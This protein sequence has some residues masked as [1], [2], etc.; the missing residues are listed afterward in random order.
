MSGGGPAVMTDADMIAQFRALSVWRRGDR[1]A[2]HKPLLVLIALARLQRG[3]PRLVPYT[4]IQ[5]LLADLI[6]Q[7]GPTRNVQPDLP[8]WY[9]QNDGV[10]ELPERE[11]LREAT[12]HLKQ[13]KHIPAKYLVE[14]RAEAGIPGRLYALLRDRPALVN[15]I[16]QTLLD[17]TFPP[18][19]HEEILDAVGMPWVVANAPRA[20][21]DPEFRR[22]IIRAYEHRCAICGYDGRLG[23]AVLGLEAAHVRWH[24][25]G[26]PDTA[27]NGLALCTFHHKAFDRG[28]L[29][30][31]DDLEVQVSQD[32]HGGPVVTDLLLRFTGAPVRRPQRA[33]DPPRQEY[34]RWH[35]SEVF[36]G[37]A[38]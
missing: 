13:R 16:S 20:K 38:R 19:L 7:Y 27:D 35:R 34:L 3:E 12:C 26:G 23:A 11:A 18:S 17:D 8:F 2:P 25:Q 31:S 30:L 24:S 29:G 22:T 5:P 36:K 9:L 33:Y 6:R 21:R 32:V 28:A 10:W 37:P 15:Q 14:H 4:E 1:R